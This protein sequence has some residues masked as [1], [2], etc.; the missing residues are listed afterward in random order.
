MITNA[1]NKANPTSDSAMMLGYL[2]QKRNETKQA[3]AYYEQAAA[4]QNDPARKANTYVLIASS[5]R[6]IDMAEAKKYALKAAATD[7]KSGEAY[8]LLGN[9]YMSA[10]GCN[11]TDFDKKALLWLAADMFKKAEVAEPKYKATVAALNK[12]NAVKLP[13]KADIKAAKKSSGDTIT[14]GC[15]INETVTI[16]KVK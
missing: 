10:S 6:N 11:L 13:T 8:L 1:L 16:P 12:R 2:S 3:L 15:W 14:F 4:L 7:P 5:Y 9:M